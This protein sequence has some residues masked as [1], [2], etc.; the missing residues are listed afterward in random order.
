VFIRSSA[1]T[2]VAAVA[3]ISMGAVA[4]APA[5]VGPASTSLTASALEALPI[6]DEEKRAE[7]GADRLETLL[8]TPHRERL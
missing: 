7:L 4:F 8:D 6:I 1:R 2:T 3:A 5:A